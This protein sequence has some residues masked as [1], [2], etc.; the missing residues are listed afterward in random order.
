MPTRLAW[1]KCP[2]C[3]SSGLYRTKNFCLSI[4][5]FCFC[6]FGRNKYFLSKK[7]K[8]VEMFSRSEEGRSDK[9]SGL[10]HL[11]SD[12]LLKVTRNIC[13]LSLFMRG[14]KPLVLPS[15]S[16]IYHKNCISKVIHDTLCIDG[17]SLFDITPPKWQHWAR[18]WS[19]S[20]SLQWASI[21][22]N[23]AQL[24][25]LHYLLVDISV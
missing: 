5:R 7:V 3:P 8:M 15:T 2:V 13:S 14:K 12:A 18:Y 6:G 17:N 10:F 19:I 9:I 20:P 25:Y 1:S 23:T 16:S 11:I 24:W 4:C 21:K 22:N